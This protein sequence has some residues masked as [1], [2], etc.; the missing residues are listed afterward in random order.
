MQDWTPLLKE[1]PQERLI[2]EMFT[3]AHHVLAKS[4]PQGAFVSAATISQSLD[5]NLGILV[6][7]FENVAAPEVFFTL[8]NGILGTLPPEVFIKPSCIARLSMLM[9]F[10]VSSYIHNMGEGDY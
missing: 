3:N 4:A 8:V 6:S 10:A 9:Y 2:R 1:A 5:R 7:A